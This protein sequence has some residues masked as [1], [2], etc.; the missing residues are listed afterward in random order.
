MRHLSVVAAAAAAAIA[1]GACG[2]DDNGGGGSAASGGG[3]DKPYKIVMSNGFVSQ[4]RTQM[5]NVAEVMSKENEPYKGN[6][7]FDVVV[8]ETSPTAQIQSLNNIIAEHPDAIL[9]NALSPTALDP[10]VRKACA[11]DI[12][13]IYFDQ[14][15]GEKCAYRLTND[16][17]DLFTN[18][19]E[20]LAKTLN[21]KGRIIQ[22]LGLPGSPVSQA[23]TAAAEKVFSKYPGIEVVARYEGNYTPGPTKQ[24]V[25]NIVTSN[26]NIDG[27][28]GIAGV[29]GA[30]Q[31]FEETNTPMV[32]MTNFGDTSVRL[33]KLIQKEKPN[34]LD[35]SMAENAPTLGGQAL[36]L[37]WRV[38]EGQ[39][40]IDSEWGFTQGGDEK[41]IFI[42]R[43]AYN[44][45]G[46]ESQVEGL[47][48]KPFEDLLK[49]GKGLP[50]IALIPYSLPQ[51]PVP[52]D[53]VI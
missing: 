42:P 52:P 38:L 30:V 39:D 41:E 13:V 16:Y 43:V 5:Q 35:F 27:V 17:E 21:G 24:A 47:T 19:A 6:V 44:T 28:Y 1:L 36:H 32:P 9:I 26:Q 40:P 49:L 20:W 51:S 25:T 10:V 48:V 46:V 15:G 37:A 23:G 50:D 22:D 8:S 12:V 18:N 53:K 2:G 3:G 45:N 11:Q 4:W 7:D 31:A 29:D 33:N 34:G 14:V